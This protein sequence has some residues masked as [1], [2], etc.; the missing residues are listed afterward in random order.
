MHV[1]I[2]SATQNEG[3]NHRW[4]DTFRQ[5]RCVCA[6]SIFT[7]SG[8]VFEQQSVAWA[9]NHDRLFRSVRVS[10]PDPNRIRFF[11]LSSVASHFPFLPR[12]FKGTLE[13][14]SARIHYFPGEQFVEIQTSC[15]NAFSTHALGRDCQV[16]GPEDK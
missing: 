12:T 5:L 1:R 13:S 10:A 15:R 4:K 2:H 3:Q 6:K 7:L 9:P 11:L 8:L 16:P 14:N